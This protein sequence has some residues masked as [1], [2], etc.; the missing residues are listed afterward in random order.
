MHPA[1]SS[2][3]IP[4]FSCPQSLPASESFPV[5]C[6]LSNW[7][8][9]PDFP[10]LWMVTSFSWSPRSYVS[11]PWCAPFPSLP[12]P[13]NLPLN[14]LSLSHL[15][16]IPHSTATNV[17]YTPVIEAK[18]WRKR[19]YTLASSVSPPGG[20]R[21]EVEG[22]KRMRRLGSWACGN[23][24]SNSPVFTPLVWLTEPG[25][26]GPRAVRLI[27]A[28]I[29]LFF[30]E[31]CNERSRELFERSRSPGGKTNWPSKHS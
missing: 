17:I 31:H 7:C 27:A 25:K 13:A 14:T 4:F 8:L 10:V 18:A 20:S 3:V 26:P 19:E 15:F 28:A 24:I 22:W 9:L 29:H 30:V 16:H 5:L 6:C 2:F 1:I 12:S 11:L 23:A 21:A